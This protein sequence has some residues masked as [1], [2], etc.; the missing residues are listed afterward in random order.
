MVTVPNVATSVNDPS[1]AS[2]LRKDDPCP[3]SLAR[4][5]VAILPPGYRS[6]SFDQEYAHLPARLW[7]PAR[8]Q[9]GVILYSE[10]VCRWLKN[11]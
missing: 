5:L 10:F 6:Y 11:R 1:H 4:L 8:S 7:L 9:W 2:G 3:G